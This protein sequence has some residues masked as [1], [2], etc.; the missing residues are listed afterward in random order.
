LWEQ[1]TPQEGEDDCWIR[2]VIVLRIT[3]PFTNT[4]IAEELYINQVLDKTQD[5]IKKLDTKMYTEY[6]ATYQRG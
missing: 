4:E 1:G 3:T 5:Y 6:L 2:E